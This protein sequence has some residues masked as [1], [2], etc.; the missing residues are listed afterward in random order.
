MQIVARFLCL[1][2]LLNEWRSSV[3]AQASVAGILLGKCSVAIDK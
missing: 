3:T 1:P 2:L